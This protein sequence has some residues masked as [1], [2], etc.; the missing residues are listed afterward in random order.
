M[1]HPKH[2]IYFELW[3]VGIDVYVSQTEQVTD[4]INQDDWQISR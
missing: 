3:E 2:A 1:V 4:Q